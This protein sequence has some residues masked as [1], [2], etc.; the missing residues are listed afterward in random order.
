MAIGCAAELGNGSHYKHEGDSAYW[1]IF[2]SHD[3]ALLHIKY[4]P[5]GDAERVNVEVD[6]KVV[7]ETFRRGYNEVRPHSSLRQLTPVVF[8]EN[9][10]PKNAGRSVSSAG[11]DRSRQPYPRAQGAK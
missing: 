7:I 3:I 5:L 10:G 9:S 1:V 8:L 4:I 2:G 11:D 6:A